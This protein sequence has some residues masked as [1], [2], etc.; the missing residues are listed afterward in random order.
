[1]PEW[2]M[3][4]GGFTRWLLKGCKTKLRDEVEGNLDAS[5]GGSY[6]IENLI[7][8]IITV[9]IILGLIIWLLFS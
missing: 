3:Y 7:I 6:D 8:G 1:M 5:W 9:S 2:A 4:I